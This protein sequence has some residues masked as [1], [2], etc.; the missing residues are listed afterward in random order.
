MHSLI[1][2]W[3]LMNAP[4]SPQKLSLIPQLEDIALSNQ[5]MLRLEG[6]EIMYEANAPPGQRLSLKCVPQVHGVTYTKEDF[7]ELLLKIQDANVRPAS[8][9][10]GRIMV[11]STKS[12][13]MFAS[14]ACRKS[15]MI[16]TPL[17]RPIMEKIVRN[18]GTLEQP[19][20]SLLSFLFDFHFGKSLI[21][22]QQTELSAWQTN[23]ATSL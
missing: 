6:W 1:I 22:M 15:Y 3:S 9:H 19:W 17:D 10:K 2:S 12:L 11:R 23:N 7:E 16:G 4:H 21:S 8:M 20:V 13:K 5:D 18:L 14:K